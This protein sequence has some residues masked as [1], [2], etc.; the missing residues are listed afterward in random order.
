LLTFNFLSLNLFVNLLNFDF[1][2]FIIIIIVVV[3]VAAA[4]IVIDYLN[5]LF[6][7]YFIHLII[8]FNYLYL[9]T[10]L[11]KVILHFIFIIM[12]AEFLANFVNCFQY[13]KRFFIHFNLID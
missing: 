7:Y 4:A 12:I 2:S 5:L 3:A 13:Q 6:Q 1:N 9:S 11:L 8:Y 10:L